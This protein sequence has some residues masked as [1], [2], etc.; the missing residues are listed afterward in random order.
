MIGDDLG[1]IFIF[2][3]LLLFLKIFL[4]WVKKLV[5]IVGV[6]LIYLYGLWYF[7]VVFLIEYNNNIYV[8]LKCLG[9][10][11]VKMILDKYG[12]LYFNIN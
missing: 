7:Y 6:K 4:G 5:E 12:Y 11:F 2:D 1:F 3:G 10:F 9:Y 8:V